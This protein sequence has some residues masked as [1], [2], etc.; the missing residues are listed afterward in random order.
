MPVI[1][2]APAESRVSRRPRASAVAVAVAVLLMGG[3]AAV[4]HWLT[5]RGIRLHQGS[6][7]PLD[8]RYLLHLTGWLLPSLL[9]AAAI[10]H[11]GPR[12]A[13]GL[14]WRRLLAASFLTAAGWAVALAL[15]GGPAAIA[16]PLTTR[17]EYLSDV[18]RVLGMDLGTYLRTFTWYIVD[19]GHGPVWTVH[20]SG[21]PPLATLVFA[22]LAK[23]GLGGAGW[24]A[25]LC[26]IGGASAAA[27][28]LSTVRVLAGEALARAA[29]PFVAAAPLA[30]W[31]ATSADALFTGVAAAG[32]CALAHAAARRDLLALL[33]GLV[34]GACLFLS[35]G[36]VLIAPLAVAAVAVQRRIRPLVVAGAAA[37]LVVAGFA[38]AGF[39]WL[40]GLHLVYR[41]VVE[42][43]GYLDRPRAYFAFAGPAAVAVQIGPAIIAALPLAWPTARHLRPF[44]AALAWP[45]RPYLR[46]LAVPAAALGALALAVA[47]DL[48]KG[49]VERIFLPWAVWLLPLA[50]LL[51]TASRRRWLTAQLAFAFVIAATTEL[52]W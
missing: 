21:H 4:G 11:F 15:V 8:G 44:T 25:A 42:G 36:L 5:R 20:V 30:L 48:A 41:R 51:P 50:A 39:W 6:L 38:V 32:I 24:A 1:E 46:L 2:A 29:A 10:V 22:L 47:S 26:I 12:L 3:C 52:T 17:Y 16:A 13:A 35:Y 14:P 23:A 34:L 19:S 27:S 31:I 9:L 37:G 7:Y 28:V 18:D 40:D 45:T 49:E 43:G 33:G